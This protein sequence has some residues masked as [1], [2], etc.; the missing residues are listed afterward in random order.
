ME[1]SLPVSKHVRR[2]QLGIYALSILFMAWDLFVKPYI[3]VLDVFNWFSPF[4]LPITFPLLCIGCLLALKSARLGAHGVLV[5]SAISLVFYL[6]VGFVNLIGY[7]YDSFDILRFYLPRIFTFGAVLIY[8]SKIVQVPAEQAE[9]SIPILFFK[10]PW[11][12]EIQ[13]YV[14]LAFIIMFSILSIQWLYPRATCAMIGGR[15][16]R[17]GMFGQAQYCL[18]AYPDAGKECQSSEDCMGRCLAE[19]NSSGVIT[20][21]PTAGVCAPDNGAFGCFAIFENQEISG[22][23]ID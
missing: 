9:L 14:I 19:T 22:Y 6:L 20:V 11:T 5:V 3:H 2:G 4:V 12:S 18:H 7:R 15:W 10:L 13:R 8:S 1:K 23:C 17:D 16:I 21:I